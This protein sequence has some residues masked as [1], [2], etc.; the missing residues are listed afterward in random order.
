MDVIGALVADDEGRNEIV[1]IEKDFGR[2]LGLLQF[3]KRYS[4]LRREIREAGWR[5]PGRDSVQGARG[6]YHAPSRWQAAAGARTKLKSLWK[7][8]VEDAGEGGA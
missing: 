7:N 6:K 1:E 8:P 4:A 5:K 2:A 3:R